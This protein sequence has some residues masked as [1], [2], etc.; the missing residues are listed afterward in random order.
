MINSCP[1]R[2]R[3]DNWQVY[4]EGRALAQR[5]GDREPPAMPRQDMLDDRQAETSSA[6]GAALR[7]VDAV[8]T[9][10]QPRQVLRRDA[11]PEIPDADGRLRRA[12]TGG[13]PLDPD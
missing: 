1:A 7:H 4:R 12:P 10:R 11:R 8:E 9:F 5:A 2:R 6:L 3:L 13:F